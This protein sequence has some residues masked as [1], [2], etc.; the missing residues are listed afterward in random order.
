MNQTRT[1]LDGRDVIELETAVTLEVHTKCPEKWMLIDMQ[2][3]ERYI[4]H[5]DPTAG[6]SHWKKVETCR[7]LT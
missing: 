7:T 5:S 3:G 1:L 6:P 2:T 4:G